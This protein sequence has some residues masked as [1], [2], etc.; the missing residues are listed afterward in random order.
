MSYWFKENVINLYINFGILENYITQKKISI[1][2]KNLESFF[3]NKN[4]KYIN[5]L[6]RKLKV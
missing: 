3:E 4:T 1:L 5:F 2:V 6:I